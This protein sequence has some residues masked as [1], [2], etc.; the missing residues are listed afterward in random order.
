[1]EVNAGFSQGTAVNQAYIYR[2]NNTG[3]NIT[4]WTSTGI[5]VSTTGGVEQ[6][7]A[8]PDAGGGY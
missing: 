1:M 8:S 6:P 2:L 5:T 3:T 4:A 7:N